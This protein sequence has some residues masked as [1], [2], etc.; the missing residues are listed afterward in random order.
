MDKKTVIKALRCSSTA[1]SDCMGATCPYYVIEQLPPELAA[2][3]G[4]STWASCDVDRIGLDAADA[5]E[6]SM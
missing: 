6:A 2:K 4:Q 1:G 3:A 5:L